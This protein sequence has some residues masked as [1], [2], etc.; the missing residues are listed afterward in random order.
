[1]KS[2]NRIQRLFTNLKLQVE[3]ATRIK[4]DITSQPKDAKTKQEYLTNKLQEKESE[5][6]VDEEAVVDLEVELIYVLTEL[7][8]ERRANQN[9][10]CQPLKHREATSKI[11]DDQE[12]K[13]M[14]L[15]EKLQK[16][17]TVTEQEDELT[18]T[19]VDNLLLKDQ[20]QKTQE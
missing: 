10:R 19:Q 5:N 14:S 16:K 7:R 2:I 12:A 4:E 17:R 3:V 6:Y 18:K 20:L 13:I 9:I 11:C 8:N 15:K 1:M